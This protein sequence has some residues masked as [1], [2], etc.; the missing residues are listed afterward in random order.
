MKSLIGA[1]F[2]ISFLCNQVQAQGIIQ[3]GL[4][5][6][7]IVEVKKTGA[8]DVDYVI[9]R[10]FLQ[11]TPVNVYGIDTYYWHEMGPRMET[12]FLYRL[13]YRGGNLTAQVEY[14]SNDFP[15]DATWDIHWSK[16]TVFKLNVP[17]VHKAKIRDR[18]YRV[19]ITMV[20]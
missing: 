8:P 11:E 19:S 6:S 2:L 3:P 13:K 15:M 10:N 5:L 12:I 7:R 16:K 9:V 1:I 18:D 17:F 4:K 20:K 14:H